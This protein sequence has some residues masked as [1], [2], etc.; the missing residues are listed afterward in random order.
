MTQPDSWVDDASAALFTDVYELAMLQAYHA[1]GMHG[2]AVF[3]L[4]FR[5]LPQGRNYLLA[6]GLEDVLRYLLGQRAMPEHIRA[7]LERRYG[8]DKPLYEQFLYV[9]GSIH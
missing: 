6:C 8:L 9:A 2:H 7:L 5:R 1:E 3:S 4:F